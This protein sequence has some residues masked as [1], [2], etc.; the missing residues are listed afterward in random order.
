MKIERGIPIPSRKGRGLSEAALLMKSMKKGDS[1]WL[2]K[3]PSA[4][5]QFAARYIGKSKYVVR[6]ENGGTRVWRI[7]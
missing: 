6:S 7:K 5:T 1:L 4:V 3:A 2:K